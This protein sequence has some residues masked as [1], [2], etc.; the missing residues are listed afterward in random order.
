MPSYQPRI[1]TQK[2]IDKCRVCGQ[3]TPLK[4]LIITGIDADNYAITMN[5]C[6]NPICR[7][8]LLLSNLSHNKENKN[9]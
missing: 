4:D 3:K 1:K 8:C 7:K 9:K 2:I 5:A 6:K